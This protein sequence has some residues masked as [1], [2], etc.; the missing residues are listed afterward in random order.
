MI[1]LKI[2]KNGSFMSKI[3]AGDA[4]DSFLLE[5]ARIR[6]AVTWDIDGHLNEQFYPADVWKDPEQRPYDRTQWK[7]IRPYIY[8]IIK[9]KQAPSSFHF[10]L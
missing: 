6:M 8:D 7:E 3:L 10:V 5:E 2:V 4:F 1:A 9:G